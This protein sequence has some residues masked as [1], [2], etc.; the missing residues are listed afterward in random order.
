VDAQANLTETG[1][2]Y[3]YHDQGKG[4]ADGIRKSG[5]RIGEVG[6]KKRME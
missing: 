5:T 6:C 2:G 4:K 3:C 1:P